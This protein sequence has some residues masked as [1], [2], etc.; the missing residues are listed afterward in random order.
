M[1]RTLQDAGYVRYEGLPLE[2]RDGRRIE[3]EFVS[4]VY[5]VDDAEVIQC[6]IRDITAHKQAEE[7]LRQSEAQF[8]VMFEVASIGM[9]QADVRT[10]QWLC[11]NDKLC[12]ITGVGCRHRAATWG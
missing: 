9:A 6:N 3:V 8:R 1:V 10:G 5:R 7:A 12:T 11:V 2:T 4:N